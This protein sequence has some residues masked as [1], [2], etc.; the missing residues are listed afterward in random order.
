[1]TPAL[2]R[3]AGEAL[4]GERWRMPLARDLGVS[5]RTIRYWEAERFDMPPGLPGELRD[6][7]RA[8]GRAVSGALAKLG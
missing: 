1:M 6:L 8:K 7:L 5:D 3:E 4:H 2:L